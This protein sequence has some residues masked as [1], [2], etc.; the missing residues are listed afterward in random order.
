MGEI[1]Q[2]YSNLADN[3]SEYFLDLRRKQSDKDLKYEFKKQAAKITNV[4]DMYYTAHEELR[5]EKLVKLEE[6]QY[7]TSL[8]EEKRRLEILLK[9]G[10]ESAWYEGMEKVEKKQIERQKS[11]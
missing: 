3:K 8:A 7:Q 1:Q 10:D 2:A 4:R 6:K 9:K 11:Q 5:E